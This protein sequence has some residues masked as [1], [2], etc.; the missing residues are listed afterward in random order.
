MNP[1]KVEMEVHNQGINFEVDT[2]FGI[3]LT[4]ET[5]YHKKLWNYELTNT[6]NAVKTYANKNFTYQGNLV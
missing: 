3:T 1:L 5:T 6:K 2:G 4:P